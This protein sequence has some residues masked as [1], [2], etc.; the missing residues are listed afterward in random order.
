MKSGK[1]RFKEYLERCYQI[2]DRE[3]EII[4][5]LCELLEIPRGEYFVREGKICRR[6]AFIAEGAMRYLRFEES[7]E[8]TTCY[9]VREDDFAGDP[10]SFERQKPSDKNLQAITDCVLVT[11]SRETIGRLLKELPRWHEIMADIDRKT[12]MGLLHQRDFLINRDAASKYEW[13]VEHFPHILNRTPLG[14][15][16]SFLDITQQSLSRIRKNL[17]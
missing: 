4:E 15:I 9:F 2:E 7:G 6:L 1:M 8:D 11:I 14:Y 10:E 12:M 3:W 17:P 5:G 13:F 16:A